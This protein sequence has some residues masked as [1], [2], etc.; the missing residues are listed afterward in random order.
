M[1]QKLAPIFRALAKGQLGV[2]LLLM[3]I[4]AMVI[5]PIPAIVLDMLF[6]FNIVLACWSC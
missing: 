4:L 5:L 6:T 1:K 2:P 3:T